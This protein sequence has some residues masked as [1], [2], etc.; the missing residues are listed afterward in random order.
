MSI[1]EY[2]KKGNAD[3]LEKLL[4]GVRTDIDI[5]DD[6]YGQTPIS[7]A[8][9]YGYAN[10]VQLLL[11]KGARVDIMD[12][13]SQGP[14]HWAVWQGHFDI[15]KLLLDKNMGKTP[16][17]D[18]QN[19]TGQTPI[20]FAAEAG[21]E[22]ITKYLLDNGANVEITDE[23][24]QGPLHWA[25]KKGNPEVIKLLLGN[26][27][28]RRNH[29]NDPESKY[30][31]T[32]ISLAAEEGHKE[33]V[34]LLLEKGAD[35]NI[36]DNEK[37][38]PLNVAAMSDHSDIVVLLLDRIAEDTYEDLT[39]R[40][41]LSW[42][43]EYPSPKRDI[44][45]L[46]DLHGINFL[47]DRKRAAVHY[48]ARGG[49]ITSLNILLERQSKFDDK[50][51]FGLTP[52]SLAARQGH[53]DL[54]QKLCEKV[55]DI[56][57]RDNNGF[58]PL[59]HSARFRH[60]SCVKF[61]LERGAEKEHKD[62]IW[63]KSALA[64]AA[65]NGHLLTVKALI[66]G[67]ADPYS[68]DLEGK[69]P[70]AY[71][72]GSLDPGVLD[73]IIQHHYDTASTTST[74]S[75]LQEQ[76]KR[77]RTRAV[78]EAF[79][80][81]LLSGY[82][83]DI[84]LAHENYLTARDLNGRSLVSWVAEK[85][86]IEEFRILS[87]QQMDWETADSSGRT[88][89]S[90]AAASKREGAKDIVE[91]ILNEYARVDTYDINRKTPL[92]WAA[93]NGNKSIVEELLYR[94]AAADPR[95]SNGRTPLS[96]AAEKGH[97]AVVN[98][99]LS[100]ASV[101]YKRTQES[102]EEKVRKTQR[103]DEKVPEKDPKASRSHVASE[104]SSIGDGNR[105][106][107]NSLDGQ[108][109]TPLHYAA[110]NNHAQVV[111]VLLDYGADIELGPGIRPLQEHPGISTIVLDLLE[112]KRNDGRLATKLSAASGAVDDEFNT[113]IVRFPEGSESELQSNTRT[114]RDLLEHG[115]VAPKDSSLSCKWLHLPA[116]NMRWVEVLMA[117]HY[118]EAGPGYQTAHRNVLNKNWTGHQHR[119]HK[120]WPYH[121]RFMRPD[122][123]LL[124]SLSKKGVISTTTKSKSTEARNMNTTSSKASKKDLPKFETEPKE[125]ILKTTKL[126]DASPSRGLV[127]FMPYL[128]WERREEFQKL[129]K[130]T[131]EKEKI[132]KQRERTKTPS[133]YEEDS[134]KEAIE[135]I[136]RS[137]GANG[138]EKMYWMYLDE[139]HPLH[140]RRTLDQYYYHTLD[141]TSERDSDQTAARYYKAR[142]KQ[143]KNND[144][145]EVLTM[146]DQL[147]MW[148]LPRCGKAP[149][150][151]IT[152]FPQ[153]SNRI[154]RG[155][156]KRTTGLIDNILS[157]CSKIPPRHGHDLA[158]VIAAE[159]GRIYLDRTSHRDDSI[160]FYDI[161]ST[162][163]ADLTHKET[164]QF[165][166]FQDA[167]VN[168]K[169]QNEKLREARGA[170]SKESR[171]SKGEDAEFERRRV[172][173]ELVDIEQDIKN[174]KEI[175]DIQDELNIMS[176]VFTTQKNVIETMHHMTQDEDKHSNHGVNNE[177]KVH[178]RLGH[179]SPLS[180]VENNIREVKN[181]MNFA[182]MT[183]EA[184][185]ELL[186][187]KNKQANVLQEEMTNNINNHILK[188]NEKTDR[189]GTTLMAFTLI[190]ILFLPLSFMTSFFALN[191]A[192]FPRSDGGSML[193]LSFVSKYTFPIS[194]AF[195]IGYATLALNIR[196]LD[197]QFWKKVRGRERPKDVEN[198]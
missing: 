120:P 85:G 156:P 158:H 81:C 26:E 167:I 11:Q 62:S 32:P 50:D 6:D 174:L 68:K 107:V 89:L 153:R 186:D 130:I 13:W 121:S 20:S 175:K 74:T 45:K 134:R 152:A 181:L 132:L 140:P 15:V 115:D 4:R 139:Q 79:R 59:M 83:C 182:Q 46:L 58:T 196:W 91:F 145:K 49:S 188:L 12:K 5:P 57:S 40:S 52:L 129:K 123:Q 161:Y 75:E 113:L 86:N 88:P 99:L 69:T 149:C 48:A 171:D 141:D 84:I 78:E 178:D 176:A 187:L 87:S 110:T 103:R 54:V 37:R 150:T 38:R 93:E 124:P 151:V 34:K 192:E 23:L 51:V 106:E 169:D 19:S 47:D 179:S 70:V 195:T 76:G 166:R 55:S 102:P 142:E 18:Q 60:S 197:E 97:F 53:L 90:W 8:S 9:E 133:Q 183:S 100:L 16:K 109:L 42:A 193:S 164:N 71:A 36:P 24:S 44:G 184:L 61:L 163:I 162:S 2:A 119:T 105:V 63:G 114:V 28:F 39:H 25:A 31:Q 82:S 72:V 35:E 125:N 155:R 65:E 138:T 165:R 17:I 29:L 190:T 96:I 168:L 77:I 172:L 27:E 159:C 33:V 144:I 189:Q 108:F 185:K 111:E 131:D 147:W 112:N 3:D 170:P 95:D 101:A 92:F 10:V 173:E 67:G 117:R 41:L 137:Q 104:G 1:L 73:S 157:T 122:C 43:V 154:T 80:Y 194:I 127:L 94:N 128:H 30:G 146:V 7:W 180:I 56:N 135:E 64:L 14:L 160:Q 126:N 136:E 22:E 148:V 177:S 21:H 198:P 143:F 116:N 98:S 191:I 66:E 118:G